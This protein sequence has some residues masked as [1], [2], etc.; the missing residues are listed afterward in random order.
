MTEINL[1]VFRAAGHRLVDRIVDEFED[2]IREELPVMTAKAA[3]VNKTPQTVNKEPQTV[4]KTGRP[5]SD[6]VTIAVRAGTDR[7]GTK[8]SQLDIR[9]P[10]AAAAQV[11][12]VA[13]GRAHF[14]IAGRTM[15][16][17]SALSGV[18]VVSVSRVTVRIAPGGASLGLRTA[19][20][21]TACSWSI[22]SESKLIIDLPVWWPTEH[23]SG[24]ARAAAPE[25]PPVPAKIEDAPSRK[26]AIERHSAS[27]AAPRKGEA[28]DGGE[29]IPVADRD[30]F[31]HTCEMQ[32]AT[33]TCD[34]CN[35]LFCAGCWSSHLLT[36]RRPGAAAHQ[37]EV[38]R[39]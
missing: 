17:E 34:T 28:I 3:P 23:V 7:N 39:A 18:K 4:N 5:S 25:A 31:C 6:D 35:G 10:T 12:L 30:F 24:R 20:P 22:I 16:V 38:A 11:V 8:V 32:L 2:L 21:A 1:N 19:Q 29:L 13:G 37:Q 14:T 26:A 36:H 15:I 9:I 27:P 33:I